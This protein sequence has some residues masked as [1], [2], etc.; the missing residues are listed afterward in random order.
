MIQTP[1]GPKPTHPDARCG[2]CSACQHVAATKTIVLSHSAP[3][4]PGIGQ[5][6]ADLWNNT[7]RDNPCEHR[8][9]IIYTVEPPDTLI[10]RISHVEDGQY[11]VNTQEGPIRVPD[12][13]IVEWS[14]QRCL[15]GISFEHL[16]AA[17]TN[18]PQSWY[19]ALLEVV[20][21]SATAK[22]VFQTFGASNRVRR[23]ECEIHKDKIATGLTS[24]V[25]SARAHLHVDTMLELLTSLAE[26]DTSMSDDVYAAHL[27]T[28]QRSKDLIRLI[29]TGK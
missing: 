5:R 22:N 16:A 29:Q 8:L 6:E 7:L 24:D 1:P 9:V 2:R 19:P 15:E 4:G 14:P 28:K 3:A 21:N 10:G 17:L 25:V 11:V 12:E 23:I 20:V 18:M 13:K 26:A 27:A